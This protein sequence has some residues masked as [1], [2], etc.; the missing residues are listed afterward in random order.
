[1]DI[2]C[3]CLVP[4]ELEKIQSFGTKGSGHGQFRC[5]RGVAVDGEGNIVIADGWNHHIQ[6]FTAEG[7]FL[8]AVQWMSA[9]QVSLL[10]CIQH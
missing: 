6:K 8:T 9:I 10:H 1:M 4:M 5:P 7:K 3:L 2:V